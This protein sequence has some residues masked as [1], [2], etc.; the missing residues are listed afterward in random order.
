VPEDLKGEF[1]V[2][3]DYACKPFEARTKSAKLTLK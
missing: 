2:Q 3:I 1:A